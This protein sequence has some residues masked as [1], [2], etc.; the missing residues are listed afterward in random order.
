[1]EIDSSS[2]R[3]LEQLIWLLFWNDIAKLNVND[4]ERLP[5]FL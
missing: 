5:Q 2:N 3:L 1:M 4:D